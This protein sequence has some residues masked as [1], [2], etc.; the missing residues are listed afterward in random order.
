M[1]QIQH[2]MA[3]FAAENP[4]KLL[5]AIAAP[6]VVYIFY[7]RSQKQHL[8]IAM[9]LMHTRLFGQFATLS[10]LVSIM[11]FKDYM[12]TNGKYVTQAEVDLRAQEMYEMRQQLQRKLQYK[13]QQNLK[14]QE[15]LRI[16]HEQDEAEKKKKK[17]K[18]ESK[19]IE[20]KLE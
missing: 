18:K 15:E 19:N 10:L 3:N 5:L 12:D 6:S 16:A 9:K 11:G 2:G 13:N 20:N 7:G 8:T 4:L 14:N 17:K 1:G